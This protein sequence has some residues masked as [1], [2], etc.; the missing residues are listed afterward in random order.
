MTQSPA[1]TEQS[2]P[3]V[4]RVAVR[5]YRKPHSGITELRALI[6]VACEC[7]VAAT[8]VGAH[9]T[10]AA[11]KEQAK[12]KAHGYNFCSKSLAASDADLKRLGL[13]REE[14][15]AAAESPLPDG[16]EWRTLKGV[17]TPFRLY[18]EEGE[19]G[20]FRPAGDRKQVTGRPLTITR[21]EMR[22]SVRYGT[23]ENGREVYLWGAAAKFWV[24]PGAPAAA[25][26]A[27]A[28]QEPAAGAGRPLEG[29]VVTHD[30]TAQGCAP[31]NADHPDVVA[32]R[33]ALD[34]LAVATLTDRHDLVEPEEG[35]RHV[36]GYV[37]DPRTAGRVAVYWLEG[38][39]AVR[40][41]EPLSGVALDC[42][43]D[44]LRSRGWVTETMLRSSLCVFAHRP[45]EQM[46]TS[47]QARARRAVLH[48]HPNAHS[49]QS[50]HWPDGVRAGWTFRVNRGATAR[51]GVVTADAG[52]AP[53]G[54]HEYATTAERAFWQSVRRADGTA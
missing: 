34:G 48:V 10:I 32:A 36:R 15:A 28:T 42:L 21:L 31:R 17:A 25:P 49:L 9:D 24:L 47:A 6:H 23:D 8:L 20:A 4:I 5:A 16:P 33:Q 50:F 18:G 19:G 13:A 53:V 45:E 51:Y 11:A 3:P 39:R 12:A 38:G 1:T 7:R 46:P 26:A 35:E 30:G 2:Q 43:A 37:V 22:G 52:I 41:S 40:Y 14:P 54:L 29:V 44:R 27:T